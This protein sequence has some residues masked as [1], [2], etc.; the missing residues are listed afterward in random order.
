MLNLPHRI[1]LCC[2]GLSSFSV[3]NAQDAATAP[4]PHQDTF[5]SQGYTELEAGHHE[6]AL[7]AFGKVLAADGNNLEALLGQAMIYSEQRDNEAAYRTYDRIVQLFPHNAFAW[8][9][10]GLAAFNL[11]D[12]DAALDSFE[13][14]TAEKPTG[15]FLESLAWTRMCR[16]EFTQAAETAK[17]ACLMYSQAGEKT[18][19]PLLIAYFAYLESGDVD[20]ARR[21]LSYAVANSPSGA[22]PLPILK[23]LTGHIDTAEM[24]SNVT[25]IAQETEA[26]T[27]IGLKLRC[28]GDDDASKRH[29]DWVSKHGDRQVFEYTLARAINL[30]SGVATLNLERVAVK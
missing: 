19:Y 3:L 2:L 9:G 12:F 20:N 27:Y 15:F 16:G 4:A 21:T 11:E 14:A 10:R 18:I 23:Y 30:Q 8:N 7:L 24:L 25:S 13:H 22:W 29:F 6:K 1:F 28:E 5:I 17:Q 26:H